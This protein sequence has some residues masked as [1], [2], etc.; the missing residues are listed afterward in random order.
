[1]LMGIFSEKTSRLVFFSVFS[2]GVVKVN[3]ILFSEKRL[4]QL[5]G[6]D[7][8]RINTVFIFLYIGV[9][10]SVLCRTFDIHIPPCDM[11]DSQIQ[12]KEAS[13]GQG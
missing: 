9:Q 12:L 2:R 3:V 5:L 13:E 1:M 8:F 7:F 4:G 11:Y 6:R 10:L